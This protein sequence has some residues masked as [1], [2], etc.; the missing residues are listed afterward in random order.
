MILND[1]KKLFHKDLDDIYG[2]DEVGSFFFIL[3]DFYLNL[4]RIT[5]VLEPEYT[6]TKNEEQ[7]LF[8]ALSLLKDEVPIQHI[9]GETEFFGL[10]FKVTR[11]T[12][13]PRPETEEL[14]AWILESVAS[15]KET[16]LK[17]LDIGTGTGCIAIC[18]AKNLPQA[19]VYAVDISHE[20]LSVATENAK[21]NNVSVQFIK[22]SALNL[23]DN[24][25]T[26]SDVCFD[27]IV[28]NPPYVR[29][30]EKV[31]IKKNVLAYEP[32]LA[33]FVADDNPLQ[34]YKA[35]TEFAAQKLTDG[36]FLFFEINQYLGPETKNLLQAHA[37]KNVVL[38]NDMFSNPRMLKGMK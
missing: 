8:E 32:H 10:P 33:L 27:V 18:L 28:S 12:L 14:V 23:T 17:I 16:P 35:I 21:N 7:P 38:K 15:K 25:L 22:D 9:V 6:L 20:A 11:D 34:F 30:L 1:I 19:Q 4:N 5:L 31:E 2:A 36:G 13:I 26:D 29:N 24:R 3:I 37:L